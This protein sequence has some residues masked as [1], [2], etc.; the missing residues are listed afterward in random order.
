MLFAIFHRQSPKARFVMA[1]LMGLLL[2]LGVIYSALPASASSSASAPGQSE[3]T[4]LAVVSNS[5]SK[6]VDKPDG[7]TVFTLD[8]GAVVT[9]FGRTEDSSWL[10]VRAENGKVGWI[11]ASDTVI[12]GVETLAVL[13]A[14]EQLP[15]ASPANT[16]TPT[17]VPPTPTAAPTLSPTPRPTE[18]PTATATATRSA[19]SAAPAATATK[20][21]DTTSS[22]ATEAATGMFGVVGGTGADLKTSPDGDTR[23]QLE[24]GTTLTLVGRTEA[25]DWL[26]VVS[27]NGAEG[28]ISTDQVVAFDL[29][30]LPV[31]DQDTSDAQP[32]ATPQ[33]SND[34]ATQP[35]DQSPTTTPQEESSTETEAPAT[36]ATTDDA[37]IIRVTVQTTGA[38]LRVRSGPG[39]GYAIIGGLANGSSYIA[40][41]RDSFG[42]WVRVALADGNEGWL[43][44][45]YLST[46]GSLDDLPLVPAAVRAADVGPRVDS[47]D[48][49]TPTATATTDTATTATTQ[50]PAPTGLSGKIVVSSGAGGTFYLYDLQSGKLTPVTNGYDPEISL[51]GT[52]IAFTRAGGENGVYVIDIDGKNE[53]K[54]YGGGELLSSPKWNADSSKIVF[55]AASGKQSCRTPGFGICLPD[56]P[57]FANFDLKTIVIFGLAR[58]TVDDKEYRDLP[59]VGTALAPDWNN[60]NIIYRANRGFKITMDKPEVDV[61]TVTEDAGFQD[62]DLYG[63]RILYQSKSGNHWE[64]MVMN[65]DA[66]G[67]TYLTRPVTALVDELPNNV[68]PAWSPDGKYIVYLGNRAADNNAGAWGVWVMNADGSNQRRL[69][70]ELDI[71]Y[72]YAQEQM[73]SWGR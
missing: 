31:V 14:A 47:T 39:T 54:L 8:P 22:Q 66:S 53:R 16:A 60:D 36:T 45:A 69:P 48:A 7:A 30:S 34:A 2:V 50:Q 59:V 61:K 24:P 64:I 28:W 38:S 73:V 19:A 46:N 67:Q 62:P 23:L 27:E 13:D 52:R 68:A 25:S 42:N 17:A 41:G 10:A 35:A 65:D 12:F 9:A 57:Q 43:S 5:G 71:K 18:P 3:T 20:T 40:T 70:I 51:D 55:S 29:Q 1:G 58:V 56:T 15:D 33:E 44:A 49:A 6:I 26:R 32:T 4:I 11:K 37:N 21:A 63:G 72:G